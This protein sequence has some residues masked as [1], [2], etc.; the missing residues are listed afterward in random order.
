MIQLHPLISITGQDVNLKPFNNH[1]CLSLDHLAHEIYESLARRF[2]ICLSSDEFHFFP[3]YRSVY[4]DWSVWDDFSSGSVAEVIAEISQWESQLAALSFDVIT[5]VNIGASTLIKL[6][7]TLREQLTW[8]R[9]HENQPTFYLTIAGIGLTEALNAGS[10]EFALR[11]EGLPEFLDQAIS[12]LKQLPHLYCEVGLE[13]AANICRWLSAL[14]LHSV[15]CQSAVKALQKFIHGVKAL[16]KR[17]EFLLPLE[18]Y[19]HIVRYHMDCRASLEEIK[20]HLVTEI[21]ETEILMRKA[22]R[23]LHP[24]ASWQKTVADLSKP[25]ATHVDPITVYREIIEDLYCHCYEQKFLPANDTTNHGVEIQEIPDYMRPV[26]SDAAFSMPP[27]H[28]PGTGIFYILPASAGIYIQTDYRLL[29]AHETYPGHK[30]LDNSRWLLSSALQR[31]IEFPI[32]YEGWASFSEEILFDTG[33]FSSAVDQLLI[34]KRRYW[35]AQRGLIDLSIH[36][37]RWDLATA[38][39]NLIE[40]GLSPIASKDMVRRYALKPGFQLAYTIGRQSF[41]H[42]YVRYMARGSRIDSFVRSVLG[43]GEIG[44]DNLAQLLD[45]KEENN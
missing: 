32:F 29:S 1:H 18:I 25:M 17:A 40:K 28:P 35:R 14:P 13:M 4:H 20:D 43:A 12:N 33:F 22:S 2:P 45:I 9:F 26:R 36:S 44:F 34:A 30:L 11:I 37:G 23:D 6:L 39:R 41:H 16:E 38:V 10:E 3:H 7:K 24:D 21:E 5:G 19:D 27:G 42:L 15:N 31:P 8:V